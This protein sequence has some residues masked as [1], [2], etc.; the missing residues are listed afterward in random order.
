MPCLD[1][2][3]ASFKRKVDIF[4]SGLKSLS[5]LKRR[6][7]IKRLYA[8]DKKSKIKRDRETIIS[9]KKEALFPQPEGSRIISRQPTTED[10]AIRRF[11][12]APGLKRDLRFRQLGIWDW[13][14]KLPPKDSWKSKK[15][16]T[17]LYAGTA[18]RRWNDFRV[19][20]LNAL[21]PAPRIGMLLI[22]VLKDNWAFALMM[23][24]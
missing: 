18:T 2:V 5:E 15:L 11:I 13:R 1:A 7:P 17:R 22:T 21:L 4:F 8:M 23:N 12:P 24:T 9:F 3:P 14:E 19:I 20:L 6:Y 16:R 10:P